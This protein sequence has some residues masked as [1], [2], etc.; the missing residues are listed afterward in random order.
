MLELLNKLNPA[1]KEAVLHTD[2]PL[3]ILAGAGSG[4]TRVLT[5]RVAYLIAQGV[6]P[7][8]ILAITFTNKAANKMKERITGLVGASA[9]ARLWVSTFH[10]ACVRILRREIAALG[11]QSNFVI[12]DTADQQTLIK[13]CLKELNLDEKKFTP[14]S[15]QAAISQAKNRLKSAEQYDREAADYFEQ[16]AADV[17]KL[18]QDKLKAANAL[19]FD[20]LLVLTVKLF[21][22]NRTALHYYQHK[23]QH[24]LVDEY[25]DTNHAQYVLIKMLAEVH[26]NICVVGDPDQSIYG[27]R[28]ADIQNILDFEEDYP[29]AKVI[30]LE[31]NYRSTKTILQAANH[32]IANNTGRKE[33][34]LWTENKKGEPVIC[35]IGQDERHEAEFIA[36]E[37]YRRHHQEG[38]SYREF[39]VLYRTNAQSRV[40]EETFIR[41]GIPYE[42]IGGLKFYERKE[43]KD[44]LA[45]LRV[46]ANPSDTVSLSRIINVPKRGIGEATFAKVEEFA[47]QVGLSPYEALKVVGSIP[48]LTPR[49]TK[50]IKQFSE[51]MESFREKVDKIPLT[52]LV[53][54]ILTETGYWT[55]LELEK[56]VESQTRIE[57][58]QEFLSVTADFDK[59]A[60]D[61][62][63]DAFL[64]QISLVSDLDSYAEGEAA[65]VL[66]TLHTAKGLEYPVVFLAGLEEGV[67]PHSRALLDE[68]ELEEERRLC[69]VGMTRAQEMLYMTRAWQRTLYGNTLYNPPSRFLDEIPEELKAGD[70]LKQ[71]TNLRTEA[72]TI[73]SL[74]FNKP[75]AAVEPRAKASF[76]LGDH[77][78]HAKWGEGVI[79]KIDGQGK[80]AQI[81]IAFPN[82]GIKNV[83]AQYAPIQKA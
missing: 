40:F 10:A 68:P 41:H 28:G 73:G 64:A 30:K 58:L 32:V 20:D 16:K 34:A 22:E 50:G 36:G 62:T 56:T 81:S 52:D 82:L 6:A 11:Y 79:V 38:R 48:G 15:I 47:G 66:M 51:L 26:R 19:D 80:D 42:V 76:N 55:E 65:V 67:F 12:Y 14:R 59:H 1:Q 21:K 7:D 3:L 9:A 69:Y 72:K 31:Q 71:V 45:Y 44:I 75:A 63:L 17:F 35:F 25:Q 13:N 2:G 18:Y 33:K 77:V 23:F 53:Q 60:E 4:K 39:A 49:F 78:I 24:I 37:I 27:W 46:L 61:K 70:E 57:N 29:D 5:N 83:L 74:P 43:I 8:R 54:T